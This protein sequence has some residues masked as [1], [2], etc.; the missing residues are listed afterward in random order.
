M[1][2]S[3]DKLPKF[4]PT[5]T[6]TPLPPLPHGQYSLLGLLSFMLAWSVYFS[7]IAVVVKT[8][9]ENP[10]TPPWSGMLSVCF[11]WVVLA[12]LYRGWRLRP[13]WIVHCSGPVMAMVVCLL[14]LLPFGVGALGDM[15]RRRNIGVVWEFVTGAIAAVSALL[16]LA[17]LV[18]LL[19]SLPIATLMM[20]YLVLKRRES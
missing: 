14:L 10:Q 1:S 5:L 7:A 15:G 9:S 18:S 16:S 12:L 19:V 6:P 2:R 4:E 8:V 13:A 11:A 20:L 17:C 3:F